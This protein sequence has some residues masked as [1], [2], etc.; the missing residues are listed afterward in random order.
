MLDF[1]R[2]RKRSWI[3]TF[4][5]G[6]IILVFIAFYGGSKYRDAGAPDV[7]QVNGEVITKEPKT[8]AGKRRVALSPSLALVLRQYKT[9]Q[10]AIKKLSNEDYV[11]CHVDGSPYDPSTVSHAFADIIR[12]SGLPSMSLHD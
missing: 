1:L 4:L 8:M 7:A 6:V 10:K 3:I 5:L 2:K 11:F 9:E 12:R